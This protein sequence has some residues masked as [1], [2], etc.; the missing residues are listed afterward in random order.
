[1]SSSICLIRGVWFE[2]LKVNKYCSTFVLFDK[3]FRI[4]DWLGLI[5]SSRKLLLICVDMHAISL[6]L[7]LHIFEGTLMWWELNFNKNVT[8]PLVQVKHQPAV[9]NGD[10]LPMDKWWLG[11]Q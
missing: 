11:I 5:D 4:L 9:T 6:H 8:S 2:E 7:V 10:F 3:K 1:M